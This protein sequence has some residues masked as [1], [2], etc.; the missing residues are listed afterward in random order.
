MAGD[1]KM[2]ANEKE[3]RTDEKGMLVCT[4]VKNE[5]GGYYLIKR[6]KKKEDVISLGS[7]LRQIYGRPV[8]IIIE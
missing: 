4:A 1:V 8:T 5:N 2:N 6:A 3:I 7:F